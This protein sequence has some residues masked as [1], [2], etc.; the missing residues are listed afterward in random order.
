MSVQDRNMSDQS[1][2]DRET[3]MKAVKREL[4]RVVWDEKGGRVDRGRYD[5]L[6]RLNPEP[7]W[8]YDVETLGILDVNDAAVARYGYSRDAFLCLTVK[9]LRP[10]ED[11]AK[12]MELT[13]E[14]PH[15][16]RTG[17]WRHV[18]R[19]GTRVQVLITSHSVNF[20]NHLARL[21]MAESLTEGSWPDI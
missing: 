4:A 15:S 14:L 7:M 6:F 3:L 1:S 11:V 16:D 17:P 21:V 9:D 5:T 13:A 20:D 8:I 18:L 10:R 2:A 19:D 12:F